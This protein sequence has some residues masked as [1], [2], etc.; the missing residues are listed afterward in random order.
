[1]PEL[2]SLDRWL[3]RDPDG[4]WFQHVP[5]GMRHDHIRHADGQPPT[6]FGCRWCGEPQHNHGRQPLRGRGMHG[7]AQPTSAQILARMQ[8]RR[9]ARGCRCHLPFVD[10][11]RCEADDCAA[12]DF[13]AA[14]GPLM[15]AFG[16]T[17]TPPDTSVLVQRRAA[18]KGGA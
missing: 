10:P 4:W 2:M 6:P 13:L 16:W 12:A 8:A 9:R 5:S 17:Q 3:S 18:W 11:Y 14:G 1:M 7:W 15:A